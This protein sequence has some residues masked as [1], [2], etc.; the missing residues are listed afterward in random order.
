MDADIEGISPMPTALA[1]PADI[2]LRLVDCAR[3]RLRLYGVTECRTLFGEL[4][5]RV[6]WGRIGHRRLRERSETFSDARALEQRRSELLGRRRRH[7]YVPVQ[8]ATAAVERSVPEPLAAPAAA[9]RPLSPALARARALQ[10]DIVQ[11]HG[12]SL[13]ER[14]VR[15]LVE[16]WYEATSALARYLEERQPERLDLVDVSTLAA[17]YVDA[18]AS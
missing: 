10:Q 12:L 18:V 11:A 9:A 5:L 14:A 2:E 3:N 4:C 17:M 1:C 6:Q 8:P 7:G 13:R 15:E 16:R